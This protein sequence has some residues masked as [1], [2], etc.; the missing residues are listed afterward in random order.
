MAKA[1]CFTGPRPKKL[2]GY[3]HDAYLP[4][5]AKLEQTIR[6]LIN[7]GYTDFITGAAQGVDQLA[8]WA[9]EHIKRE[10]PGKGIRNI[11]YLP[12]PEF[13]SQWPEDTTFGRKELRLLLSRADEVRTVCPD[14]KATDK[15]AVSALFKRNHAMVN[16][17]EMV[18]GVYHGSWKSV[19]RGSGTA[20]CLQYAEK[21]GR[22]IT[23]ID[24]LAA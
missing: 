11:V 18:V 10:N 3:D 12:F 16:D 24:P 5:Y 21:T 8:F 14:V 17:S 13:G 20:E 23:T 15:S 2:F 22:Y 4:L 1:C 6:N 7:E 9:V 19:T